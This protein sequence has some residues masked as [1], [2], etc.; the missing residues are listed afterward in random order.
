LNS[1]VIAG[2]VFAFAFG[3][4]VVGL[5]LQRVLPE[6][7]LQPESK[8]IIK[9]GTGLIATMA[10]L[11]LVVRLRLNDTLWVALACRQCKG[12]TRARCPC[13]PTN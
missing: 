8:D 11:I 4:A 6:A 7:H 12:R 9:L 3:G 2:I 10:A 1:I 13:H 5:V